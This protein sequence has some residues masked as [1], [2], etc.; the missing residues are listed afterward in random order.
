MG[1]IFATWDAVP[2]W[3]AFVFIYLTLRLLLAEQPAWKRAYLLFL[4]MVFWLVWWEFSLQNVFP[5]LLFA[6]FLRLVCGHRGRSQ[7]LPTGNRRCLATA[8]ARFGIKRGD[9]HCENK[10][11]RCKSNCILDRDAPGSVPTLTE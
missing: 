4:A 11:S 2:V 1:P 10:P 7:K 3:C 8:R 9:L 5:V 6:S